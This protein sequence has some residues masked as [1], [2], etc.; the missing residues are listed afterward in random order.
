MKSGQSIELNLLTVPLICESVSCQPVSICQTNFEHLKGIDLADSSD[1][2]THMKIDVLIGSD[3][4]WELV[5][6]QVRRGSAGPVA[7]HTKLGW[8]LSG[9]TSPS[10]AA[11]ASACLVTHTLRVDGLAQES[12]PLD[13]Q[14]R[15]FWELESFGI[16]STERSVYD[17][18]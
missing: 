7:I 15:T 3:L 1:G 10:V 16:P 4:Y 5:T 18:F 11:T 14:L 2:H 9:V 13:D 6:G 17:E 8:V 12:H